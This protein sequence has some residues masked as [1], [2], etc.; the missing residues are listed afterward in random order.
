MATGTIKVSPDKLN[1]TASEFSTE[2]SAIANT[3][4]EMMSLVNGASSAWTGDAATQFVSRF[5]QLQDDMTKLGKMAEEYARDLTDIAAVYTAAENENAQMAQSLSAE[6][7][8]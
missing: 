5:G 2:A 4:G 8:V 7:I 3:T 6:V 1:Q